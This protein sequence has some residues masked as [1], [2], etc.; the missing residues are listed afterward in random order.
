MRPLK[1]QC[2]VNGKPVEADR[3]VCTE[4][5]KYG[6]PYP[7]WD[8]FYSKWKNKDW[9]KMRNPLKENRGK[10]TDDQVIWAR[11]N[12]SVFGYDVL[13]HKMNVSRTTVINAV[14]GQTYRHLNMKYPPQR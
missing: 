9:G 5:S 2:T 3:C 12:I 8:D 6:D 1:F 14:T 13:C 4:K 11:K 7:D 10:L